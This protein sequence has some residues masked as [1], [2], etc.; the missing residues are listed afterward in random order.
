VATWFWKTS[1]IPDAHGRIG[2]HPGRTEA[3]AMTLE[4]YQPQDVVPWEAASGSR[5]VACQAE[6][7]AARFTFTGAAGW[8]EVITQYF[9]QRGGVASFELWLND[10]RVDAWRADDHLPSAR[11]DAHTST[12]RRTRGIALRP[13]DTLRVIGVPNGDDAAAIDYVEVGS[14]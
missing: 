3:E 14:P 8:Y 12:W 1:G 10:Q 2:A 4:G 9:D 5:G 6:R 7:C 11:L 13:G